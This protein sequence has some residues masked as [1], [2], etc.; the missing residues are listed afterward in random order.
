MELAPLEQVVL[1]AVNFAL[2]FLPLLHNSN[3]Y[4]NNSSTYFFALRW[5]ADAHRNA[6][7]LF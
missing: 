6:Y 4:D 3:E 2:S 7:L 5:F 1:S